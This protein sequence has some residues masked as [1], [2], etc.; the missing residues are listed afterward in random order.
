MDIPHVEKGFSDIVK[1]M[2]LKVWGS[3]MYKRLS[4][5]GAQ[6]D[7]KYYIG[8]RTGQPQEHSN[9]FS[10]PIEGGGGVLSV[11]EFRDPGNETPWSA[12]A[13][14]LIHLERLEHP[15]TNVPVSK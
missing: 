13:C 7:K 10:G 5:C 2:I 14:H 9:E 12:L 8:S 11:T 15:A 4:P 3:Y 1:G 6:H